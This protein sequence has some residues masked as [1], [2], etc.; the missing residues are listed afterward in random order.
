MVEYIRLTLDLFLMQDMMQKTVMPSCTKMF[1]YTA[2]FAS[3]AT[4][5]SRKGI[6]MTLRPLSV[7]LLLYCSLPVIVRYQA[8]K[9]KPSL[10][11]NLGYAG[12]LSHGWP[13]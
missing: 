12:V 10:C 6:F 13:S 1:R 11:S 3:L 2:S 5:L 7:V 9:R 4:K 8:K